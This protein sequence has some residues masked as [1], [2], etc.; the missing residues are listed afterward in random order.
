MD[1]RLLPVNERVGWIGIKPRLNAPKLVKGTVRVVIDSVANIL[2]SPNG[3]RIRQLIYGNRFRVLEEKDNFSFGFNESDGYVGYIASASLGKKSQ[4]LTHWVSAL[5]THV[6]AHPDIKKEF[7]KVLSF[8]SNLEIESETTDFFKTTDGGYIPKAHLKEIGTFCSDP[9]KVAEKFLGVPYLWGGNSCW[10]I[11]CSGI[12]QVAL[13]SCSI[14]CPGDSDQ[15]E[16]AFQLI[17][18]NINFKRNDLIFWDGH[19]ALITNSSNLIHANAF[20]MSVKIES[21]QK[22]IE[23]IKFKGD[24]DFR[25]RE[26]PKS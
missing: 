5:A 7:I 17:P 22:V 6:Y 4:S 14:K 16:A 13:S 26:F 11:D 24:G 1:K 21:I 12:V 8:G 3:M 2:S 18:A 25:L 19:V 9:A 20:N 10:G 23:R 15:Q